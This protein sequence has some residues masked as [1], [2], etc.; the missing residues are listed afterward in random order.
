MALKAESELP[1]S[2]ERFLQPKAAQHLPRFAN[3]SGT[4]ST[5]EAPGKCA[6]MSNVVRRIYH[7]HHRT[8]E[9]HTRNN[10]SKQRNC[11]KTELAD[12]TTHK[13]V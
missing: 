10:G 13:P 9:A 5:F 12:I 11:R 1:W 6:T 4:I 7:R 2:Y 3:L 8:F